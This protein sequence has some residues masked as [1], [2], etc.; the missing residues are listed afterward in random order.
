MAKRTQIVCQHLENVSSAVLEEF[1]AI[2]REY[3]RGRH[4]VYAL[5]RRGKLYYVGLA[6]NLRSRLKQHLRDRHKGKWDRFSIYLTIDNNAIKELE[7]LLLRIVSPGGNRTGGRF[8]R[9]ENLAKR[10]ARDIKAYHQRQLDELLGIKRRTKLEKVRAV[11]PNG[12]APPLSRYFKERK[13]L[14]A[15]YKGKLYR[16][17]VRR[18][19]MVRYNRKVYKSPSAA[20]IAVRKRSTNGWHFWQ[21]ERAPGDWVM[22]KT[23][24]S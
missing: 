15:R 21:Y 6:T 7:T 16:A 24:R 14:R 3:I 22:L 10:F 9:S 5:Y 12:S 13:R 11:S 8:V 18:D 2:I 20:G 19:G 17:V 23:L 4:G 1:Q